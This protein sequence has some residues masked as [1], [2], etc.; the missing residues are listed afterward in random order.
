MQ[1]PGDR[2]ETPHLSV[3]DR[4]A[5]TSSGLCKIKSDDRGIKHK[6]LQLDTLGLGLGT[7]IIQLCYLE[8]VRAF[9]SWPQPPPL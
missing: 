2:Q 9:P 1:P 8:Q 6:G 5:V 4:A 7:A 3:L